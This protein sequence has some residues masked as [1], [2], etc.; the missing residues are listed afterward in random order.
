MRVGAVSVQSDD[1]DQGYSPCSAEEFCIRG[2][3]SD[4]EVGTNHVTVTQAT[5]DV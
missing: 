4:T 5:D 2:P 1:M 3:L